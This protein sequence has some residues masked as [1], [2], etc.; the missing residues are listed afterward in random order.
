M[1]VHLL[2]IS[3]HAAAELLDGELPLAQNFLRPRHTQT[4]SKLV[5]SSDEL[6][7]ST[8]NT[9][10]GMWECI[11]EEEGWLELCAQNPQAKGNTTES[12]PQSCHSTE[13]LALLRF[14]LFLLMYHCRKCAVQG[15]MLSGENRLVEK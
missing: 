13:S 9:R 3:Q 2:G 5:K 6:I 8:T 11:A 14:P 1:A 7:T 15:D 12:A 10:T 4:R